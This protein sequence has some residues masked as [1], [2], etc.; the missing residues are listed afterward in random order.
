[1]LL[2]KSEPIG[3]IY[4]KSMNKSKG[5]TNNNAVRRLYD[6]TC[7]SFTDNSWPSDVVMG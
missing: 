5:A 6:S 7:L 1:M 4:V 2:N 3:K